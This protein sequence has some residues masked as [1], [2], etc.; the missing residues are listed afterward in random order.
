METNYIYDDLLHQNGWQSW[1]LND[2]VYFTFED[3][4]LLS[5]SINEKWRFAHTETPFKTWDEFLAE[6]KKRKNKDFKPGLPIS[7][8]ETYKTEL[9]QSA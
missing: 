5:D 3:V 4:I 9:K 2:E 8:S 6:Y 7:E 1:V